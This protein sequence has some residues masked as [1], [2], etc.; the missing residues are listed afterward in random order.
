MNA[1]NQSALRTEHEEFPSSWNIQDTIQVSCPHTFESLLN[2]LSSPVGEPQN[3]LPEAALQD[4]PD[5]IRAAVKLAGWTKLMPVQCRAIPYLLA[6]R[7]MLI[8]ARTGSG[9]TGAFLLPMVERLDPAAPTCQALILVPTRELAR[10][11]WQEAETLCGEVGLRR[12]VI[13]GGVGYGAQIDALREGAHIVVGT[14]G[15]ILDHLLK[16]TLS[17]DHLEMLI[18][19][20]ADRMLSMGFYPDMKQIQRHLPDRQLHS[21]MFSA[22]FPDFIQRVAREFIRTPEFLTLSQD[23]VHVTDTE[24][25]FYTV[26]GME[27]DR[28]LMRIVEIENPASAII[29]CNTKSRVRYVTVVLQQ[30][31]YDADELSADRSQKEREAVLER[32]RQGTL[33]FLVATDVAARGLDIPNL[34]HVI[35]YEPPEDIEGYIHRAGRT[36][37]AGATGVA[38]SLVSELERF[39]LDRIAKSYEIDMQERQEPSAADVEAVVA[40]RVTTLLEA[41]LRDRDKLKTERSQR[42]VTLGR[43]LAENEDESALIAM[44]LDDYYQQTLHA[45][46]PQAVQPPQA[47]IK[48]KSNAGRPRRT[49]KTKNSGPDGRSRSSRPRRQRS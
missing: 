9:K 31:G 27:K 26:P 3:P 23:H 33:R 48:P 30:F 39:T 45:P 25:A 24:H 12:A 2:T 18:F 10:Q 42:F 32:V 19:D 15:R 21:C 8:Q 49:K 6:R 1:V 11:V 29:F 4:L 5:R 38:L 47:S 7:D 36:G 43:S 35:Q 14:P 13:Y 20:E 28:T 22:T 17:L 37:R 16:R 41:R 46:V 40:E 44:L 34:S